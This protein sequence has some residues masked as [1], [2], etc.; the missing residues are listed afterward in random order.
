[1]RGQAGHLS[2]QHRDSAL[3]DSTGEK[4]GYTLLG[5]NADSA[6]CHTC[7]K[8]FAHVEKISS[9]LWHSPSLLSVCLYEAVKQSD[10]KLCL[11]EVMKPSKG[12]AF[13]LFMS[14]TMLVCY[15]TLGTNQIRL[16]QCSRVCNVKHLSK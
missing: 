6:H 7:N 2:L 9:I 11:N 10:V 5:L 4:F 13:N 3:S 15:Y 14:K 1:M 16:K 12:F 8:V